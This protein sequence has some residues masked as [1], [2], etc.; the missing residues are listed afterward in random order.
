MSLPHR[1]RWIRI[2][3][4]ILIALLYIASVP[5]YRDDSAPLKL[6]LGLPDWVTV[7]VL[8]YVGVAILNAVAWSVTEVPDTTDSI[9]DER[10]AAG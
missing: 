3:C 4:M 8:C 7:A 9:A 6:W 10:G 1:R 2:V 5:W